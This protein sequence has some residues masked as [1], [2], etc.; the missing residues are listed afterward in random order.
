MDYI[1]YL[2]SFHA[3]DALLSPSAGVFSRN[4][5][6]R[7]FA[8]EYRND[9]YLRDRI[10][11]E[12]DYIKWSMPLW[13][14]NRNHIRYRIS[15]EREDGRLYLLVPTT[16]ESIIR[17]YGYTQLPVPK[18]VYDYQ[19][20]PEPGA[21]NACNQWDLK[22]LEPLIAFL[23]DTEEPKR[24]DLEK[25]F[26]LPLKELGRGAYKAAYKHPSLP[27]VL[28]WGGDPMAEYK[29]AHSSP[30]LRKLYLFPVFLSRQFMI[31]PLVDRT[32][33]GTVSA[34]LRSIPGFEGLQLDFHE[35]NIGR[36]NGQPVLIDI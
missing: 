3:V 15:M 16:L 22:Q 20:L 28:K 6:P 32:D 25:Y 1:H 14:K 18:A 2:I 4:A 33:L 8:G 19:V 30:V 9:E 36:Y 7:P 11:T 34:R 17:G 12:L 27:F 31:Q 13:Q 23:Q 5:P 26:S 10:D 35:G 29:K 21:R 24:A